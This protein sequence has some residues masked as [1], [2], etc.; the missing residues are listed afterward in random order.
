MQEGSDEEFEELEK[1]TLHRFTPSLVNPRGSGHH[2]PRSRLRK[3][4]GS[5]FAEKRVPLKMALIHVFDD[6]SCLERPASPA[7]DQVEPYES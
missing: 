1:E 3:R 7:V 6:Q 2:V 4:S 5:D